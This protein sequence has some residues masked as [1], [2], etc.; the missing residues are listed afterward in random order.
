M[1]LAGCT[2]GAKKGK[3]KKKAMLKDKSLNKIIQQ[4]NPQIESTSINWHAL[5][6]IK[7]IELHKKTINIGTKQKSVK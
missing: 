1:L 4:Q 5:A 7:L 6:K 2:P 3:W